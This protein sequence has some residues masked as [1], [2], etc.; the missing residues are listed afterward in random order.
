MPCSTRPARLVNRD[1]QTEHHNLA[2]PNEPKKSLT[3]NKS[4]PIVEHHHTAVFHAGV[5]LFTLTLANGGLR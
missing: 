1:G 3:L 2:R 4:P 5:A